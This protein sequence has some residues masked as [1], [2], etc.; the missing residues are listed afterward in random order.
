MNCK[1][2][3]E[4]ILRTSLR[5]FAERGFDAVST[6]MIAS[7]LGITKGALYRH[8]ESK[9]DIFDSII[10]RMFELDAQQAAKNGVPEESYAENGA[11][12]KET[13]L[14]NLCAFVNDQFVFWTEN[15]FARQFRRMITIEQF[16]SPEMNKLYQD[17]IAAGPVQYTEDLF[18]EM[19]ANGKLND[20]AKTLGARPLAIQ[21][22]APLQL[23]IQLY[24]GGGNPVQIQDGLKKIT[25]VFE[26]QYM[27][28]NN[29][30]F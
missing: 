27:G 15:E 19:M 14:D 16:R 26:K 28:E 25:K 13:A 8:F 7:E 11:S 3:K 2:T 17:V 5:L 24:D 30:E 9:K 1:D 23:S 18:R 22:F 21:L 4:V 29:S 12:Y 20:T 6:S 10:A